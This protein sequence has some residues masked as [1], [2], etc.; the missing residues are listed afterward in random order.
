MPVQS[1]AVTVSQ[2]VNTKIVST[3]QL[4]AD[5]PEVVSVQSP[6]P[7]PLIPTP[8]VTPKQASATTKQASTPKQYKCTECGLIDTDQQRL[9]AHMLMHVEDRNKQHTVVRNQGT[10]AQYKCSLC[11]YYTDTQRTLKAHMWKHSGHQSLQY[12]TFQNGP[13]S[14]YDG[15]PLA[16]KNFVNNHQSNKPVSLNVAKPA[17][18]EKGSQISVRQIPDNATN[19]NSNKSINSTLETAGVKSPH[20]PPRVIVQTIGQ[21][22]NISSA[23]YQRSLSNAQEHNSSISDEEMNTSST[24]DIVSQPAAA[25]AAVDDPLQVMTAVCET[26]ER[27]PTAAGEDAAGSNETAKDSDGYSATEKTAATLLSLL[28]QGRAATTCLM[29]LI[30]LHGIVYY[31]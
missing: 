22:D 26:V 9:M 29:N 15:T 21:A 12:P 1:P 25:A 2:S 7:T 8:I 5:S 27:Q 20:C 10:Y 16:A 31:L 19:T 6:V 28:R 3:S 17:V 24:T 30:G 14:I 13:L 23:I 4:T 18:V 11:E